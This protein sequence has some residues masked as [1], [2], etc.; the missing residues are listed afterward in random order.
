M[1]L[2]AR[3]LRKDR[4]DLKLK[5]VTQGLFVLDTHESCL[6]FS[7][8]LTDVVAHVPWLTCRCQSSGSSEHED[9]QPSP[10]CDTAV[11]TTSLI[12]YSALREH[13]MTTFQASCENSPMQVTSQQSPR[14]RS[15]FGDDDVECPVDASLE[16]A[17][18]QHLTQTQPV[19]V[20]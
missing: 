5:R 13:F 11:M 9:Q 20:T 16:G 14:S 8:M 1:S 15:V 19:E 7:F 4:A 3:T 17:G 6:M 18:L 2:E 10:K 12:M